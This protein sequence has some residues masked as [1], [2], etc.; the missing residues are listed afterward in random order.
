MQCGDFTMACFHDY[1]ALRQLVSNNYMVAP[2]DE[3]A[4]AAP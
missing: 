2:L 1:S 4:I 3:T